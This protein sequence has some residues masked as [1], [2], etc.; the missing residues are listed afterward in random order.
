MLC[1][2]LSILIFFAKQIFNIAV[3]CVDKTKFIYNTPFVSFT[4][5]L[6]RQSSA[7]ACGHVLHRQSGS[8]PVSLGSFSHLSPRPLPPPHH[9]SN[10]DLKPPPLSSRRI[11]CTPRIRIHHGGMWV[12]SWGGETRQYKVLQGNFFRLQL[13]GTYGKWNMQYGIILCGSI[14]I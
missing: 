1:I 5:A 10:P 14:S 9:I 4:L 3:F 2:I 13:C 6:V 7:F 8:I 11:Y 12:Y